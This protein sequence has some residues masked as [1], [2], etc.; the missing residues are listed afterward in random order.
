MKIGVIMGIVYLIE[1]NN[2]GYI[3]YK[4]GITKGKAKKRL[5]EL[6]TGNSGNL[7]IIY[8]FESQNASKV[9]KALHRQFSHIHLNRE[10]FSDSLDI[11]EFKKACQIYE[12][13][14]NILLENSNKN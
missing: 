9:E 3:T 14:I 7:S 13:A 6:L 5:K 2:E 8:E 4:I 11:D 1:C 12:N 10:W